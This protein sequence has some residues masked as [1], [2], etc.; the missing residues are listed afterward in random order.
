MVLE[1]KGIVSFVYDI[2]CILVNVV[3]RRSLRVKVVICS[4]VVDEV[5][6]NV[7]DFVRLIKYSRRDLMVIVKLIKRYLK[8]L[9]L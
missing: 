4:G 2:V 1:V 9:I 7:L 3:E 6:W 8:L 5:F